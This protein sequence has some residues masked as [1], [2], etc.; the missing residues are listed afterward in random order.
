MSDNLNRFW[1]LLFLV[2]FFSCSQETSTVEEEVTIEESYKID[3]SFY[4][5]E[6]FEDVQLAAVFPDSKTFTDAIPLRSIPAIL[7]LYNENKESEN[8]ELRSFVEQNFK[9]PDK[10]ASG[11]VS[12]T[13]LSVNEHISRLWPVL[14]REAARQPEA[15]SLIPL[16]YDY[17]VPGGRFGEIYYWDSYFTMLGLVADNEEATVRNMVNNFS[18]LI[19]TLGFIPNGNR[20]YFL[21]RSQPPFYSLM[22]KLLHDAYGDSISHYLPQLIKEYNYWQKGSSNLVNIGDSERSP[23][24]VAENLILNR[25]FDTKTGP[26]PESYKEDVYL[27]KQ[28]NRDAE[29]LY[30]D[31]RAACASGWDFSS[32]W[33]A[34]GKTLQTI[35]TTKIVPVDLNALLFHLELMISRG[36]DEL[37]NAEKAEEYAEK[38][39][40][41]KDAIRKYFWDEENQVFSDYHIEKG[42]VTGRKTLAMAFPLFFELAT[43]DQASKVKDVLMKEFLK[44]GGFSTTLVKSGEQWDAPNGWAPLQW[45]TIHGLKNYG[46]QAEANEAKTRWIT[47]NQKVFKSTGKMVEKYVVTGDVEEAGGGEYPLQDGFGWSNGVYKALSSQEE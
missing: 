43:P 21:G 25:Y 30:A 47:R 3:S 16:P 19:D 20:T 33:C 46:F 23:V 39:E 27:M 9:S 37:G 2:L 7:D 18:Y 10:P 29:E 41:R 24:K 28:S 45:I 35:E 40:I 4:S 38:A 31:I 44:E 13:S 17:V 22:V 8:F 34:D 1:Y 11:F 14:T 5:T 12:D 42:A 26:R 32:R 36:F 15:G 6:L